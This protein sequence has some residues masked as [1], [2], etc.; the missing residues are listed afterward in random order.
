MAARQGLGRSCLQRKCVGYEGVI[1]HIAFARGIFDD[2]AFF[3]LIK[4]SVAVST[5]SHIEQST[6]N[7][8][9]LF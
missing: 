2:Q 5:M 6:M 8:I 1:N 4:R 3:V 7:G 9:S